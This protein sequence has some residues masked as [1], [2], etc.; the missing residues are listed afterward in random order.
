[1]VDDFELDSER[2]RDWSTALV[3][4]AV[5]ERPENAELLKHWVNHWKLLAYRGAEPLLELFEQA[6]RPLQS[7]ALAAKVHAAH[8]ALLIRCGL[9][10]LSSAIFSKNG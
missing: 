4:Y 2:S 10:D 6:P 1:M 7:Q 8:D 5:A 3:Q 9:N